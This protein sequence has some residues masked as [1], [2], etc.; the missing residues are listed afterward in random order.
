MRNL[1]LISLIP[2]TLVTLAPVPALARDKCIAVMQLV[3]VPA[4]VAAES[5]EGGDDA[6]GDGS[7][8]L[9][10]GGGRMTGFLDCSQ[11]PGSQHGD[12][13]EQSYGGGAPHKTGN[14]Q[15]SGQLGRKWFEDSARR[16]AS[17]GTSG[18]GGNSAS[19]SSSTNDS[20]PPQGQSAPAKKKKP[21]AQT[22]R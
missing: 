1:A 9:N 20:R 2:A 14:S 8:W 5:D 6:N 21:V 7:I 11:M 12:I 19:T 10:M 13:Y 16:H 18:S 22:Q 3:G 15:A 4:G 17:S